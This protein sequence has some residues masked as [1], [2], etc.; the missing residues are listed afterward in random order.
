M[1]PSP[2]QEG[3][4]LRY[5]SLLVDK[6]GS[7]LVDDL[8]WVG[9][10]VLLTSTW[11]AQTQKAD[12]QSRLMAVE[13]DVLWPMAKQ[14]LSDLQSALTD[15]QARIWAG[16]ALALLNEEGGTGAVAERVEKATGERPRVVDFEPLAQRIL[17][18]RDPEGNVIQ[19]FSPLGP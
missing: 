12:S 1:T 16:T 5:Q 3:P 10:N 2:S 15:D 4:D 11:I 19:L 7:T 8:L 9:K 17:Q 13:R 6:R 14:L 18:L